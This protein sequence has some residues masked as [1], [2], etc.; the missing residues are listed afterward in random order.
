MR[1]KADKSQ[2]NLPHG[3]CLC[4]SV[5]HRNS[6][7]TDER[8]ELIF[9]QGPLPP[10]CIVKKFLFLQ[11]IRVFFSGTLSK[12]LDLQNFATASRS[13]CQLN[14]L[15]FDLV[16]HTYDGRRVVVRRT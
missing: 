3:V 6:V 8:I 7:E 15:T 13:C 11:K 16:D 2:L 10:T 4:P 12:I 14:A 9:L 1:S 5:T